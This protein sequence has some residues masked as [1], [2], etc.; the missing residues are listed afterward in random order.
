MARALQGVPEMKI[1][2]GRSA[3]DEAAVRAVEAAYD[4]AWNAGDL[5]ALLRLLTDQVVII[6]PYGEVSI[7][8][9]AVE[10]SFTVL[11]EGV[12]RGS[13]HSSQIRAVHFVAP[14]VALVDAEAVISDFGPGPEPLRHD[15]TDVLVRTRDGWRIDHVRAYTFI[16][17]PR[18]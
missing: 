17:R 14:D 7:G 15:F 4:E 13:K 6:N 18:D 9:D 3:A 5:A 2:Q 11:F 12:A 16:P 10:A 1:E 8:R